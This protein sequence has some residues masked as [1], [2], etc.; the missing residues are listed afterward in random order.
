MPSIATACR[1]QRRAAGGRELCCGTSVHHRRRQCA[2]RLVKPGQPSV[3][4]A[5]ATPIIG[6]SIYWF[7]AR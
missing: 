6:W 7:L 5:S 3:L 2:N 1:A 4:T